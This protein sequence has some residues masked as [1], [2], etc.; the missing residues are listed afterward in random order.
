MKLYRIQ[1]N[2]KGVYLDETLKAENDKAAL[3]SFSASYD[4]GQLTEKEAPGFH[5]PDFLFITFEEVDDVT[6]VNIGETS[7]GV[8]MGQ[9]SV[10]TG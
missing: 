6:K 4:A 3:E 7:V 2:Y 10:S 5:N 8:S 1:A 9:Q